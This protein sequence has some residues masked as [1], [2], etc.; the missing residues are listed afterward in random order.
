MRVSTLIAALAAD[1][2]NV[3]ATYNL[4]A[5]YARIRRPQCALNLL[6]RLIRLH[7]HPTRELE[8]SQKLDRLLG[9]GGL[10]LDSDFR[11]LRQNP[12]FGCIISN[13]GAPRPKNC[14]AES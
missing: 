13:I 11:D 12:V 4:A 9:R 10:A 2:Y 5:A 14:F 1:P 6:D 3:H 8:V 7:A